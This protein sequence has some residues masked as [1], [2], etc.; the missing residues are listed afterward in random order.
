MKSPLVYYFDKDFKKRVSVNELG[1]PIVDWGETVPGQKK[2]M[3]L[4]VKNESKDRIVIRQPF[5]S[6]KELTID[7]FPARLFPE[8]S[9]KVDLSFTASPVKIESHKG[10]WGFEIVLG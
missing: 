3:T 10:D 8:D 2:K 4:F 5:T 6:T 1:S 7:D 9:G